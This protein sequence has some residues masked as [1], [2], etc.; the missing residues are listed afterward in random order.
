[1]KIVLKQNMPSL[2]TLRPV[3]LAIA[4]GCRGRN[5]GLKDG[6]GAPPQATHKALTFD[7]NKLKSA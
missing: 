5:W 3:P 7:L 4:L 1:M 2:S 6:M